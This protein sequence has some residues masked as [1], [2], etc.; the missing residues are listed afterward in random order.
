MAGRRA[1]NDS[2]RMLLSTADWTYEAL[3]RN[4]N[5]IGAENGMRLR[6]DRTSVAHWLAGSVPRLRTRELI[7][8]AFTRRL[9]RPVPLVELGMGD[10]APDILDA[11]DPY[12][13]AIAERETSAVARLAV[14]CGMDADPAR[15]R[16]VQQ[17]VYG[18]M[19][20]DVPVW[21]ERSNACRSTERPTASGPAG[22]LEDIEGLRDAADFFRRAGDFG[23]RHART[24]LV[25]YLHDDVV[26]RLHAGSHE[27]THL[28][29]LTE[30]TRLV[31]VLARMYVDDV[32]N[33][34]AQ[35]YHHAALRLAAEAGDRTAYAVVLRSM[36][37]H[38]LDLG[39]RR[40]A[41]RLSEAAVSTASADAP[42]EVR[43]SLLSQLALAQATMGDRCRATASLATAE[44]HQH[45]VSTPGTA[46]HDA[47]APCSSW[48][49]VTARKGRTL[50]ALGDRASAITALRLSLEHRPATAY[51]SR[52]LTHAE[53]ARLLLGGGRLDEAC[54]AWHRFLDDHLHL[55]SGRA[56]RILAE[57]RGELRVHAAH[58]P[59]RVLLRRADTAV[60]RPG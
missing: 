32:K 58:P 60:R 40:T 16:L 42:P 26:P 43:A 44:R 29:L 15:R 56:D 45:Q 6:Y 48:A 47:H 34:A 33:G 57:L 39:H 14:L 24:A 17:S 12:G 13:G 38:A 55:R 21:P 35:H 27:I 37:T 18:A 4:V 30:A 1:A 52:A 8:E 46:G 41:L 53:I 23:G 10:S 31:H 51:L 54:T 20:L 9:R 11:V 2:L 5:A 22:R 19:R 28:R 59:V 3:A 36:S 50:A 25:S 7:A 49:S